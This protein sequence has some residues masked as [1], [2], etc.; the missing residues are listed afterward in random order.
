MVQ[1]LVLFIKSEKKMFY[2]FIFNR[3]E[4]I[5]LCLYFYDLK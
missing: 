4:L 2:T 5:Y 3:M 1:K